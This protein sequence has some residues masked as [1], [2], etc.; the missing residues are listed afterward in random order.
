MS[1]LLFQR[2]K[3]IVHSDTQRYTAD[4]CSEANAMRRHYFKH[5]AEASKDTLLSC[6]ICPSLHDDISCPDKVGRASVEM[7]LEQFR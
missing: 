3:D 5:I 7:T 2:S 4:V 1:S 6:C